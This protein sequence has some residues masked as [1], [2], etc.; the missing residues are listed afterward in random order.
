VQSVPGFTAASNH[1][2]AEIPFIKEEHQIPKSRY[3]T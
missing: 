2:N 3:P 1:T